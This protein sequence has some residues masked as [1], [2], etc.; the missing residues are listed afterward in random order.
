M[1]RTNLSKISFQLS[2]SMASVERYNLDTAGV[3][4]NRREKGGTVR[5]GG[6]IFFYEKGN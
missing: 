6:Y 2:N 4:Q 1:S 5:A 3:Q